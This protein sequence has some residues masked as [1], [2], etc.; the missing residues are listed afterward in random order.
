[1]GLVWYYVDTNPA[2]SR[3]GRLTLAR[4]M[5]EPVSPPSGAGR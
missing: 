3:T 4:L 2:V 5:A 1:M